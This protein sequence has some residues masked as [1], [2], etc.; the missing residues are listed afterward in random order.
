[1]IAVRVNGQESSIVGVFDRGLQFA[2]GLFE[3]VAFVDGKPRLWDRHMARLASGCARLNM[4]APDAEVLRSEADRANGGAKRAVVKII[5]TRGSDSTGSAPPTMIT[6][7]RDW[8]P[9]LETRL[10]DGVVARICDTRI[11]RN[12][13]L[14]GIKHLNRLEYVLAQ[15]EVRMDETGESIVR[16]T[17]GYV[18][19][20][21][22]ANLFVVRGGQVYTSDLRYSGVCGVLRAEILE[23]AKDL[24][25]MVAVVWLTPRELFAADEVF[26]T[27]AVLGVCPVRRIEDRDF[28]VGPMTRKLQE[29][30]AS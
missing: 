24:E 22:R 29:A 3:T 15:N 7:A 14:A 19:E 5:L 11:S 9:D 13:R 1:L 8:P 20:T 30:L 26:V 27:N 4:P 18:I 2:D 28:P 12:P 21:C 16:D 25:I 23:I 17:Q 10:R 6:A